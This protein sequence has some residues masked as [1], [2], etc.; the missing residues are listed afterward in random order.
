VIQKQ[1]LRTSD[2]G[3]FQVPLQQLQT[4]IPAKYIMV[5]PAI[6]SKFRP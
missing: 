4:K 5:V 2:E 3:L 6:P 1:P